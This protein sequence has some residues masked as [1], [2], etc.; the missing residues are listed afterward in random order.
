VH[1]SSKHEL[2]DIRLAWLTN[3]F[4]EPQAA[5]FTSIKKA[6]WENDSTRQ[7]GHASEPPANSTFRHPPR[8]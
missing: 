5:F 1:V 6:Y 2:D 3:R 4:E 8:G 7:T